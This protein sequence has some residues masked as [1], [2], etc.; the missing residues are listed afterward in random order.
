MDRGELHL[1]VVHDEQYDHDVRGPEFESPPMAAVAVEPKSWKYLESLGAALHC[2][3]RFQE[4]HVRLQEAAKKQGTDGP[5]S[6]MLFFDAMAL[7]NLDLTTKLDETMAALARQ[8]KP[9][10]TNEVTW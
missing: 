9:H 4:A 3:G 10:W 8:S 2:V 6:F 5:M 1:V 7:Q